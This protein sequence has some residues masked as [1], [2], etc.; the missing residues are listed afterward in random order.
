MTKLVRVLREVHERFAAAPLVYGHGTDNAWDEAVA[1]VLGVMD[2]PDTQASLDVDLEQRV[3]SCIHALAERRVVER[4]PL[5]YLLGKITYCGATFH[6][7]PG[8]VVPRS[9][10][11]MWLREGLS[12]W[13]A[14]AP[15]CILDLCCGSGAI[16]IIAAMHFADAE[17][18]LA[19]LDAL[20]LEVARGNVARHGLDERV[21]VVESDLFASL[22][23]RVFDLILC[24]PP[25]VDAADMASRPNEYRHEPDHGLAGGDQDGLG[26]VRRLLRQ[27]TE[28]LSDGGV[29]ACEVG[30][31]ARHLVAAY[32]DVPFVWPD[33]P[34]GGTGVFVADRQICAV[35]SGTAH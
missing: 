3:R 4:L 9:P 23:S 12:P 26:L 15:R 25:Y 8:V 27:A 7:V 28:H 11:G 20:A 31:S 30:N 16:G 34:A 29:L 2:L 21:E 5:A 24:N 6:V 33:L 18:C 32:P 35:F 17:V 19:D 10:L 13:L 22:P 1:L 14:E